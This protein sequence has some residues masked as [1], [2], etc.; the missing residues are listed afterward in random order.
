MS[1]DQQ[2][3]LRVADAVRQLFHQLRA[4]AEVANPGVNVSHR[5]VMQSLTQAGPR[6]V[7]TL[8][9]ERPVAR[10]HIQTLMN[11]LLELGLVE[12]LPNP[13]HKRSPLFDLTPAG[14]KRFE[15]LRRSEQRMLAKLDLPFTARELTQLATGLERLQDALTDVLET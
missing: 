14:R 7:P 8:A 3:F 15:A 11:E 13:A 4:L 10:Q 12:A 5:G 2:A 6:S 9:R 1:N